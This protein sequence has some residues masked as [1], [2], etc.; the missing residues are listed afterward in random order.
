MSRASHMQ[1]TPMYPLSVTRSHD[2]RHSPQHSRP[3]SADQK[4][5]EHSGQQTVMS[6]EKPPRPDAPPPLPPPSAGARKSEAQEERRIMIEVTLSNGSTQRIDADSLELDGENSGPPVLVLH[7]SE[8]KIAA[9]FV[10]WAHVVRIAPPH[11]TD[12][13]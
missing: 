4:F 5:F 2:D 11:T 7:N 10:D 3:G 12:T 8:G 1:R 9:M 6:A 13:A